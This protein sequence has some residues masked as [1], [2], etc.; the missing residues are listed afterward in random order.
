M[1]LKPCNLTAISTDPAP[2]ELFKD[3]T[4]PLCYYKLMN[5]TALGL[6]TFE[7]YSQIEYTLIN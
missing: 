7:L 2:I 1:Q 3:N 5:T 4:S 6:L